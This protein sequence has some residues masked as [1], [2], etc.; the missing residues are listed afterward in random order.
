LIAFQAA[1][2]Q[3]DLERHFMLDWREAFDQQVSF[4]A[5]APA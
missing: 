4:A 2:P 3:T 1:S 5:S